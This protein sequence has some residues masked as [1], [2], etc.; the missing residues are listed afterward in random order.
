MKIRTYRELA[1]AFNEHNAEVNEKISCCALVV[2]DNDRNPHYWT[3]SSLSRDIKNIK[4]ATFNACEI[5]GKA[6]VKQ[7]FQSYRIVSDHVLV[8]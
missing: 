8:A 6:Y 4:I 3:G 5:A 7:G 2:S 1:K